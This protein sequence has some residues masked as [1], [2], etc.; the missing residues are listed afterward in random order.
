[1]PFGARINNT[2]GSVQIDETFRSMAL[3]SKTTLY[4]GALESIPGY[5]STPVCRIHHTFSAIS[6]IVAVKTADL[7]I[8]SSIS[9]VSGSTWALNVSSNSGPGTAVTAYIFD[10][11]DV[12]SHQWGLKVLDAAGNVTY[13]NGHRYM[14]IAH[15][16]EFPAVPGLGLGYVPISLGSDTLPA[17]RSYATAMTQGGESVEGN[18]MYY[19]GTRITDNYIDY[20]T[21]LAGNI[22]PASGAGRCRTNALILDVT[23][24]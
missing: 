24:Y 7:A 2:A 13:H 12:P 15:V 11:P 8:T 3:R 22:Y 14:S 6:P 9:Y 5:F 20:R 1:M 4:M 19:V 17:G 18:D 10:A 21:V 16:R 23:G